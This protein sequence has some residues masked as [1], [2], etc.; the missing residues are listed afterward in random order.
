[1]HRINGGIMAEFSKNYFEYPTKAIMQKNF[2]TLK[3]MGI[4]YHY[5]PTFNKITSSITEDISI[6]DFI[7]KIIETDLQ[8][9]AFLERVALALHLDFSSTDIPKLV[10]SANILNSLTNNIR[11]LNENLQD[12]FFSL[13][14][15]PAYNNVSPSKMREEIL[16]YFNSLEEEMIDV[17]LEDVK[18]YLNGNEKKYDNLK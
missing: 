10:W 13:S 17:S 1:M 6:K 11:E 9:A 18:D 7:E 5:S 12:L 16:S 4:A 3:H 14:Q 2:K 8:T 15:S